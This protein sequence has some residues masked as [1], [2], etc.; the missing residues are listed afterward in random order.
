M[1]AYASGIT[2]N[3]QYGGKIGERRARV[4]RW[5]S[6]GTAGGTLLGPVCFQRNLQIEKSTQSSLPLRADFSPLNLRLHPLFGRPHGVLTDERSSP[7][8]SGER[9]DLPPFLYRLLSGLFTLE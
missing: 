1:S 7:R 9:T 8:L 6:D 5:F 4:K 3:R 2:K